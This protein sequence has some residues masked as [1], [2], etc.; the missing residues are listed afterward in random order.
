MAKL[1]GSFSFHTLLTI[2]LQVA[3]YTAKGLPT[4]YLSCDSDSAVKRGILEGA[5][6]LVFI[7]PEMLLS[8]KKWKKLLRGEVYSERLK[9]LV[10][11]EAHYIEKW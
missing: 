9:A 2:N 8:T 5:F 1:V 3:S 10:V 4:A 7:S 6:Q 11:T